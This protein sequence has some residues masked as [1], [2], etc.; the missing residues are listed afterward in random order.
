MNS[1]ATARP[2]SYLA[3]DGNPRRVIAIADPIKRSTPAALGQLQCG[4]RAHRHADRR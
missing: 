1:E 4:G 2:C 3:V